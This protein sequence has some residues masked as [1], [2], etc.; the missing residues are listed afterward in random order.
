MYNGNTISKLYF[1]MKL[2]KKEQ[3]QDIILKNLFKKITF[4]LSK[5]FCK[6]I[7]RKETLK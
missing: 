3:M 1:S 2:E 4:N 6:T 7:L 5:H